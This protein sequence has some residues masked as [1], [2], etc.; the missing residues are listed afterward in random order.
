MTWANMNLQERRGADAFSDAL[1]TYRT[2]HPERLPDGS[3]AGSADDL[4]ALAVAAMVADAM[5]YCVAVGVDFNTVLAEA[6]K[7]AGIEADP[8][9]SASI[10]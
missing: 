2:L 10:Q 7:F 8:M 9:W 1:H 5:H 4:H 3:E 6:N